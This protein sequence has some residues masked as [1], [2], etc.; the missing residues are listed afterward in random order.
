[1]S[2]MNFSMGVALASRPFARTEQH[3]SLSVITPTSSRDSGSMTTGIDPT[4][5]SH[6]IRATRCALSVG[7]QQTGLAVII[8]LIFMEPPLDLHPR[9][10]VFSFIANLDPVH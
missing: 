3:R 8:S 7:T 2:V 9:M 1:F 10:R 4:L 6:I 5:S